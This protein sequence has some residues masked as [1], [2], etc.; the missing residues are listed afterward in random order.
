MPAGRIEKGE[1]ITTACEREVLEETGLQI[2]CTTLLLVET[3]RG[4]WIRFVLTGKVVGGKL[5]TPAEADGESLQ[6]KWVSNLNELEL[7]A[8]DITHLIDKAR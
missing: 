5:K 8:G 6:A 4:S 3:A 7:R 1:N 2:E